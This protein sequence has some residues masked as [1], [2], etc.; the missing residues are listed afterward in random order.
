[1]GSDL[2]TPSNKTGSSVVRQKI[3][4]AAKTGVLALP[5][6]KLT[7]VPKAVLTLDKLRT[8][9]LSSNALVAL[10]SLPGKLKTLKISRNKIKTLDLPQL[11]T[12]EAADNHLEDLELPE[13]LV[14]LTLAG[15]PLRAMNPLPNLK[16]L[17]LSRCGLVHFD[18]V[19]P[20]LTDLNLDDN[21]LSVMPDA[22]PK[23]KRL[24]LQ[25]N[26]IITF[27]PSLLLLL[28]HLELKGNIITKAE[29]LQID[30]VD[31]FLKRK[32]KTRVKGTLTDFDVCGLDD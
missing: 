2:S 8:L 3:E 10:P 9:D 24:S 11:T 5:Q 4:H 28:D 27:P 7:V 31:D 19:F 25:R 23:L 14:T 22:C 13:S 12:L 17:D 15:N 16:T 26:R 18:F 6:H 32:Q 20:N 21:K 1:M 30:G 29:F